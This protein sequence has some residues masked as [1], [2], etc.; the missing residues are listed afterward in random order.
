MA[1]EQYVYAVTRVHA[2]ELNLLK[3]QDMEQLI[4]ARNVA[5]MLRMLHDKGW[6]SDDA[7]EGPKAMLA[8]ET[9][10]TWVLIEELAGDVPQFDVFRKANDYHNLKAAI[11]LAYS[12]LDGDDAPTA[13]RYF[14]PFGAMPAETLVKAAKEHD[15][16]ALPPEMAQTGRDAYEALADT[17]SGQ[18]CDMVIDRAA[19]VAIDKAGK[20]AD[21]KL[22]RRYAELAVDGA[23]IKAAVR[24]RAMNKSEDFIERAVAPAGTLDTEALKRAAASSMEDVY[25]CLRSTAYEDAVPALQNSMADFERWCDDQMM[26]MIRPQRYNNFGIEPLAAFLLGRQNEIRMVRLAISA[27]VNNLSSEALR[28]R[29]REMYVD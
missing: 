10:K 20:E 16:S 1:K 29:L 19:L 22:L 24:C 23:N 15:F 12:G 6:G 26:E 13:E 18:A 17:S 4:A 3:R 27:K 21:I 28:E 8:A 11:K 2:S 5:E 25:D 14:L 7:G 9:T